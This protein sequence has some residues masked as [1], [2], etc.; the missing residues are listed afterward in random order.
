MSEDAGIEPITVA[1]LALT[2]RRSIHSFR[3]HPSAR[4]HPQGWISFIKLRFVCIIAKICTENNVQEPMREGLCPPMPKMKRKQ[5]GI[6]QREGERGDVVEYSTG[7]CTLIVLLGRGWRGR[8]N[9]SGGVDIKR[10][11]EGGHWTRN[12]DLSML[13][14]KYHHCAALNHSQLPFHRKLIQWLSGTSPSLPAAWDRP[15]ATGP[16]SKKVRTRSNLFS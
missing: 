8:R 5:R 3:C 10:V 2:A 13:D 14:R 7:S 4:S 15:A 12:P 11:K 9:S 16:G 1:T 6:H